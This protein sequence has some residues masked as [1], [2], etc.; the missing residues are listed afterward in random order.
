MITPVD[1]GGPAFPH[2]S[3]PLDQ[4]GNPIMENHSE[5]GMSLRDWFAGMA[6]RAIIAK[7]PFEQMP[8]GVDE[9]DRMRARGAY[10][11]ADA[12]LEARKG[13]RL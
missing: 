9:S 3:Q 8:V 10:D 11:Y 4:Q 2:S 6:L 5:W 13:V 12:M 1:D 7:A